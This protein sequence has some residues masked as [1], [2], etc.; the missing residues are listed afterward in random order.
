[1]D[2]GSVDRVRELAAA[3]GLPL[4]VWWRDDLSRR[5]DSEWALKWSYSELLTGPDVMSLLL[6]GPFEGRAPSIPATITAYLADQFRRDEQVEFRQADLKWPLRD[7]F[8][9][10]PVEV[11]ETIPSKP[12][13]AAATL[14]GQDGSV[15]LPDVLLEGAPGQGKSTVLQFV[16][17]AHRQKILGGAQAGAAAW[18][19]IPG[20]RIPVRV[21]VRDLAAWLDGKNPFTRKPLSI[22]SEP[23]SLEGFIAGH[24]S[25]YSGGSSF[26]VEELRRLAEYSAMVLLL[27]GLDE[28]PA[29]DEREH[30]LSAITE[31]VQRLRA[32]CVS[33]QVVVSTRP[34]AFVN[35]SA[36]LP[37]H[38]RMRLL[39]LSPSDIVDYTSR[40]LSYRANGAELAQDY[41]D[42]VSERTGSSPLKELSRNPMQLSIVLALLWRRGLSLPTKRTALYDSWFQVF[43]DREADQSQLV[44]DNRDLLVLIHQYL[45]WLLTSQ[46]ELDSSRSRHSFDEMRAEISEFLSRRREN[47]AL[48]DAL[49]SGAVERVVALVSKI[50]GTLEFEIPPIREY[51][52]AR[53]LYETAPP[54]LPDEP[55]AGARPERFGSLCRN[56]HWTN[57]ARLYAGCHSVGELGYVVDELRSLWSDEQSLTTGHAA[58]LSYEVMADWSLV[59]SPVSTNRLVEGLLQPPWLRVL[60][61]VMSSSTPSWRPLPASA[62]ESFCSLGLDRLRDERRDEFGRDLCTVLAATVGQSV[63][64]AE[65]ERR[66]AGAEGEQQT[67]WIRCGIEMGV[68]TE[69]ALSHM[70]ALPA[71]DDLETENRVRHLA[72]AGLT[73]YLGDR[74]ALP[75]IWRAL[76]GHAQQSRPAETPGRG[77]ALVEILKAR[78]I[79]SR[80]LSGDL[81]EASASGPRR[82]GQLQPRRKPDG[83]VSLADFIGYLVDSSSWLRSPDPPQSW[84]PLIDWCRRSWGELWALVPVAAMLARRYDAPDASHGDLLNPRLPLISRLSYPRHRLWWRGVLKR[85]VTQYERMLVSLACLGWENRESIWELR[86]DI[87]VALDSL[88][89][90]G[91]ADLRDTMVGLA[92]CRAT[93]PLAVAPADLTSTGDER[94]TGLLMLRAD[95]EVR[96]GLLRESAVSMPAD[97][98][99]AGLLAG[100][101]ED[102]L[103]SGSALDAAVLGIVA[104]AC[105]AGSYCAVTYDVGARRIDGPLIAIDIARAVL[106]RADAYPSRLVRAATRAAGESAVF[107]AEPLLRVAEMRR[108]FRP[109]EA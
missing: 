92:A 10:V 29:V 53:Y 68:V 24:V 15:L 103:L 25:H 72:F 18:A 20:C 39:D 81:K 31:G 49:F 3:E 35:A 86:D 94:L 80:L 23:P 75:I 21:A 96:E 52:A 51:F 79:P 66:A 44:R 40:W 4:E 64:R 91:F 74:V 26:G 30:V 42:F 73:G 61:G 27:D 87:S 41:L 14:L 76:L 19:E 8:V 101:A 59:Q 62:A 102:A 69:T 104:P 63:L 70:S 109:E 82:A 78:R 88:D 34:S 106:S 85:A 60:L 93:I 6:Q 1:L 43:L 84:S 13:R 22:R 7:A 58:F 107:E 89:P 50:P 5:L 95:R 54:S 47:T 12:R 17:Q 9:D 11:G 90:A 2:T 46:S 32:V 56:R 108:W 33:L 77:V 48:A 99:V 71:A 100:L 97:P 65:W 55:R 67:W 38:V 37:G 45:G 28:V 16:A 105:L 83:G 57:V 36:P 98:A